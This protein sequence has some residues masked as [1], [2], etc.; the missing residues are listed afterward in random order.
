MCTP[1]NASFQ[2]R[3]AGT[4]VHTNPWN[5][6]VLLPGPTTHYTRQQ[7]HPAL[8]GR[9]TRA[10]HKRERVPTQARWGP[11]DEHPL[12]YDRDPALHKEQRR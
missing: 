2:R 10:K 5:L 12:A 7:H 9:H 4:S 11:R 6:K 3:R 8:E 1:S